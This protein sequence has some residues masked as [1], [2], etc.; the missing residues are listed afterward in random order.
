M[1]VNNAISVSPQDA[2]SEASRSQRGHRRERSATHISPPAPQ[3]IFP[4]RRNS[5]VI[6]SPNPPSLPNSAPPPLIPSSYVGVFD[7]VF[8][9]NSVFSQNSKATPASTSSA[10]AADVL[11]VSV[12]NPHTMKLSQNFKKKSPKV[13]LGIKSVWQ[14]RFFVLDEEAKQLRYFRKEGGK[15]LGAI[16][17]Q[18]IMAALADAGKPNRLLICVA[19]T[20]PRVFDLLAEAASSKNVSDT[21]GTVKTWVSRIN[22]LL[23][24][25]VMFNPNTDKMPSEVDAATNLSK[26]H[27]KTKPSRRSSFASPGGEFSDKKSKA[28]NSWWSKRKSSEKENVLFG[29][30]LDKVEGTKLPSFASPIPNVLLSLAATLAS[31]SDN[32]TVQ[33][34][35]RVAPSGDDLQGARQLLEDKSA[36]TELDSLIMQ[37]CKG[38]PHIAAGLIK[39]YL[40]ELPVRV[41][42][43]EALKSMPW[44]TPCFV[45]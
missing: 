31:I 42:D 5:S 13:V 3:R 39:C 27:W 12:L 10:S 43:V 9:H 14:N 44:M 33:G 29:A 34:L 20:P 30:A 21:S 16:S 2:S 35:F 19:A 25:G 45:I 18:F 1:G 40:R 32:L 24:A 28:P 38:E 11:P 8:A 4:C 37:A 6:S 41:L 15:L 17:F 26:K 23:A 22:N 7:P 36:Q